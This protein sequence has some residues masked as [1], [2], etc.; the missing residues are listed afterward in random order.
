MKNFLNERK[1]N[2]KKIILLGDIGYSGARN[3]PPFDYYPISV[4]ENLSKLKHKLIVIKG[5]CD[6]R[7]DEFVLG[8]K[9]RNKL[10]IKSMIKNAKIFIDITKEYG[11]FSNY[12]WHF[13]NNKII[14]NNKDNIVKMIF[15]IRI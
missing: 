10:K 1:Y 12:I 2:F 9:F 8:I 3:I 11:S 4:Y 5:N 13:T 7:V 15:L 6:S 14:K